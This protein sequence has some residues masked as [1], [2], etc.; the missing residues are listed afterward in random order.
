MNSTPSIADRSS[1]R[2]IASYSGLYRKASLFPPRPN[3]GQSLVRPGEGPLKSVGHLLEV[4]AKSIEHSIPIGQNVVPRESRQALPATRRPGPRAVPGGDY[5]GIR[6][7]VPGDP[8]SSGGAVLHEPGDFGLANVLRGRPRDT[9]LASASSSPGSA[10]KPSCIRSSR[11]C[12]SKSDRLVFCS[13]WRIPAFLLP[14]DG[15]CSKNR[16]S[17]RV[18]CLALLV[19][20]EIS[21]CP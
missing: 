7:A 20:S 12:N 11:L 8:E 17:S 15:S 3:Q 16:W 9:A 13:S 21:C 4:T 14:I 19:N 18:R 10:A 6:V 5:P 1:P 2:R